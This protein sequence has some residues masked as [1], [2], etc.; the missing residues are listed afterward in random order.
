M[1]V[2]ILLLCFDGPN[3]FYKIDLKRIFRCLIAKKILQ[4]VRVHFEASVS[5]N[6]DAVYANHCV[7]HNILFCTNY[8][9]SAALYYYPTIRHTHVFC[10]I[11]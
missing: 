3:T 4:P 9:Q 11:L 7:Y 6:N 5:L 8:I 1:T 2:I 10:K